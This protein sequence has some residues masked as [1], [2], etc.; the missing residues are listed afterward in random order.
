M[1]RIAGDESLH[2]AH[3]TFDGAQDSDQLLLEPPP[4][5]KPCNMSVSNSESESEDDSWIDD[6]D[7]ILE[8][9]LETMLKKLY[10]KQSECKNIPSGVKGYDNATGGFQEPDLVIIAARPRIGKSA[11]IGSFMTKAAEH[12]KKA[13]LFSLEMEKRQI[14]ERMI[15]NKGRFDSSYL[16]RGGFMLNHRQ[17]DEVKRGIGVGASAMKKIASNMAICD[18]SNLNISDLRRLAHEHKRK[19]GLDIIFVDY[20]QLVHGTK[21]SKGRDR[22]IEVGEVSRGLKDLAKELSVPIVAGAQLSRG[23]APTG[24]T[25]HKRPTLNDLRESG[26]LEQDA[27]IVVAL[28]REVDEM[29]VVGPEGE[30]AL[31]ILKYR[32][33]AGKSLQIYYTGKYFEF[34]SVEEPPQDQP[35]PHQQINHPIRKP[36]KIRHPL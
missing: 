27:D 2:D 22:H 6:G 18:R 35:H 23:P 24:R 31:T 33:G 3:E 9:T 8:L 17:K 11:L 12:G 1:R 32:H 19:H 15:I 10:E 26:S 28:D 29:G 30:A 21:A 25:K 20:I 7:S 16:R 4:Q 5:L 14:M 36:P 34:R 13:L